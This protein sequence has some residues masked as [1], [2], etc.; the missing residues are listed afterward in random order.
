M[1]TKADPPIL[2]RGSVVG[3]DRWWPYPGLADMA[4]S[5]PLKRQASAAARFHAG[6]A[7]DIL[8]VSFYSLCQESNVR[9]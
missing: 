8:G 2:V 9:A 6:L 5:R 1:I 3:A 4:L 7:R